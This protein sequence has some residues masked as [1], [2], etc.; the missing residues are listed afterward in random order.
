MPHRNEVLTEQEVEQYLRWVGAAT[1]IQ[2]KHWFSCGSSQLR[3]PLGYLYAE[4]KVILLGGRRGSVWVMLPPGKRGFPKPV[5][6][7]WKAVAARQPELRISIAMQARKAQL[8]DGLDRDLELGVVAND[9]R[10]EIIPMVRAALKGPTPE[11]SAPD[12]PKTPDYKRNAVLILKALKADGPMTWRESAELLAPYYPDV[13]I[14]SMAINRALKYLLKK[15][16]VDR[17]TRRGLGRGRPAWEYSYKPAA[18]PANV[19]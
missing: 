5:T 3:P 2:L 16:R 12:K 4:G 9:Y 6:A 13:S 1:L 15:G 8:V 17:Q 11:A 18:K 10:Y 14:P 7:V 19:E